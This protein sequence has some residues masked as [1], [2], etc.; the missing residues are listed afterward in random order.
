MTET[1]RTSGA[2]ERGVVRVPEVTG[3]FHRPT[4]S[5]SY[6]VADPA[7]RAAA[8]IDTVLDYDQKAGRTAT[9]SADALA[10]A[11]AARGL[12]VAWIL[13][14]HLH[15][16]HLSAAA[17][18]KE[19]LG[20][21][22]GIG[23]GVTEIQKGFARLFNAGPDFTPDGSQFDRLFAE[24]ERFHIGKLEATVLHTPGHTPGC[25]SYLIG[26]AVFV[27]DALFMPDYGTARCDFPGGDARTLYRSIQR[28]LA[29]PD[30]TRVFTAHDYGPG[31]RAFAWESTVAEQ[32]ARNTHVGGGIGE[33]EFVRLREARD[34][35][36]E[37][38]NLIL[39]ALQVNMRGGRLPPP[40]ENGI[41]Y[42]KIPVNRL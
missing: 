20:G 4:S 7:T 11:V 26:D 23:A 28:L 19:R 14:T 37:P 1:V 41:V 27:G 30:E 35:E 33:A 12:S 25:V 40:E 18:L 5:V 38:P 9:D 24:G 22:T 39:P 42:L 3:V 31:G 15:A 10:A 29:L 34:K 13:E 36:L 21:R 16:D 2:H 6:I 8:L 17:Y 32:R